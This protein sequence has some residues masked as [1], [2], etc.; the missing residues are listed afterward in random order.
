MKMVKMIILVYDVTS[1][2]SFDNIPKW[3]D[4]I[5]SIE[6]TRMTICGNK[7]DLKNKVITD[8]MINEFKNK[9]QDI[10]YFEVSAKDYTNMDNMFYKIIAN[11]PIFDECIDKDLL[12]EQLK[13]ENKRDENEN[14][15]KDNFVNV[16][17][18]KCGNNKELMMSD[19]HKKAK[20]DENNNKN[21]Y[22]IE[23]NKSNNIDDRSESNIQS[24]KYYGGNINLKNGK[25]HN[26]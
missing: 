2:N 21:N 9:Y 11:L 18:T 19:R 26:C 1:K 15:K 24:N 22:F 5:Q 7:I 25:C 20:S 8:D 13:N 12:A 14:I 3:I 17:N 16:Y 4:F 6:K 10:L 23:Y